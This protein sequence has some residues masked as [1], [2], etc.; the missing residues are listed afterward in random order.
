[1]NY[2]KLY[3]RVLITTVHAS[4]TLTITESCSSSAR[5]TL[6]LSSACE[7][8]KRSSIRQMEKRETLNNDFNEIS[9]HF[10]PE[11]IRLTYRDL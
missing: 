6:A 1:M 8:F 7:Y 10:C 9:T 11:N 3:A 4:T 2:A 5:N